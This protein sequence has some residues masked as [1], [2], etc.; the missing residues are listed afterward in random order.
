MPKHYPLDFSLLPTFEKSTAWMVLP[1]DMEIALK[2]LPLTYDRV[3]GCLDFAY[4]VWGNGGA[5]M[6]VT[7]KQREASLRAALGEFVSMEQALKRDLQ[8]NSRRVIRISDSPNP[9]LHVVR[10]LR[11]LEM[12]LHS[13]TLTSLTR[14]ASF[15]DQDI[16]LE[17]W[18]ADDVTETEFQRLAN[19]KNYSDED[20]TRMLSWFNQAQK[21]WG[22]A[23]L[24]YR[25]VCEYSKAIVSKYRLQAGSAR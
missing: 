18:V 24:I 19:A 9:L 25:C 17:I 14:D 5:H 11:N 12:H 22:I 15:A 3:L 4:R 8:G 7:V 6:P 2:A 21:E 1:R 23:D 10:E 13:A 16:K 20:I